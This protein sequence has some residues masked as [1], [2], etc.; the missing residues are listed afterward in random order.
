MNEM[1]WALLVCGVV[2]VLGVYF[3]ARRQA[4]K[5]AVWNNKHKREGMDEDQLD[6]FKEEEDG[7]F[8]EFGVSKPRSA[9][10]APK[11]AEGA[12]SDQGGKAAPRGDG[13]FVLSV[14]RNDLSLVPGNQ[15]HQSLESCGLQ[16]GAHE[17]YHRFSPAGEIVFSVASMIK[18]GFLVPADKDE[19]RTPG[20]SM[21]LQLPGCMD[22]ATAFDDLLGTAQVLAQR[23]DGTVLD[24]Q[25]QPLTV[26]GI[27][28]MRAECASYAAK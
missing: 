1:Q 6:F 27:E 16:F 19:L 15:L 24:R 28:K 4:A 3:H 10:R 5:Q 9:R 2:V 21:F 26:D 20:V 11:L 12:K 25:R 8:D 13:L 22:G 18:P 17:I 23:W 7:G 14:H